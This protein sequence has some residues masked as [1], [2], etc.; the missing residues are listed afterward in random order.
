MYINLH[1]F[2]RDFG[3]IAILEETLCNQSLGQTAGTSSLLTYFLTVYKCHGFH[4]FSDFEM[5]EKEP[6]TLPS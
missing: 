3:F 2:L 6:E 4:I 5:C 1:L